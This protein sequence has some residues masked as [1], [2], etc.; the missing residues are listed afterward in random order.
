MNRALVYALVA[1]LV[2]GL[3][4]AMISPLIAPPDADHF[5]AGKRFFDFSMFTIAPSGFLLG[6]LHHKVIEK[7][8]RRNAPNRLQTQTQYPPA[9]VEPPPLPKR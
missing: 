1:W 4:F 7:R 9:A 8:E 5:A 3:L 2:S 6:L